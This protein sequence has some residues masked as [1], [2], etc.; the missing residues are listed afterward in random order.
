MNT[1]LFN[2]V[3]KS[4]KALLKRVLKGAH[5]VLYWDSL[6]YPLIS[7]N[8]INFKKLPLA[9]IKYGIDVK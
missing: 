9:V 7:S 1:F 6:E 2:T 5:H 8:E 3:D 4:V